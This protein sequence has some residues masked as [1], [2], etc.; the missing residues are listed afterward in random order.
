MDD[1]AEN[2]TIKSC[3]M[4]ITEPNRF[5]AEVHDRMPVILEKHQFDQWMNGTPDDAAELIKP[6]PED[7]LRKWPVSKRINSSRTPKDDPTLIEEVAA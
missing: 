7:V 1:R 3:A 4:V 6:A 2:Q 5:V